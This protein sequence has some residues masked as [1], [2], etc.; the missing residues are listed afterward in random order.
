MRAKQKKEC[1][2]WNQSFDEKVGNFFFLIESNVEMIEYLASDRTNIFD[3]W[4][5]HD[6]SFAYSC[7]W[8]NINNSKF[9]W[10]CFF[11]RIL[12]KILLDFIRIKTSRIVIF[13]RARAIIVWSVNMAKEK[14]CNW[15][16]HWKF[17][18]II[19][20][21][22]RGVYELIICFGFYWNILWLPLTLVFFFSSTWCGNENEEKQQKCKI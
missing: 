17:K 5:F 7:W 10:N 8:Q 22:Q 20:R 6:K 16:F 21:Q 1:C 11:M 4:K 3:S 14:A 12:M 9:G 18:R 15:N 2:L 13:R 19:R